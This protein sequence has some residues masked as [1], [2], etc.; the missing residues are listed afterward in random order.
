MTSSKAKD[1]LGDKFSIPT[2]PDIVLQVDALVRDPEAG[3]QEIGALIAQDAPLSTR[4][5][6]LANSAYYGLARRCASAEHA[7]S[8]LGVR[9]LRNIVTQ[10]AVFQAFDHLQGRFD[11]RPLWD[12]AQQTAKLC[13]HIVETIQHRILDPTELYTCGLIHDVGKIIML[14]ALGD[15]FA[16][17]A[18]EFEHDAD[19]ALAA[20]QERFQLTHPEVGAFVA[21]HWCLPDVIRATIEDHHGDTKKLEGDP[22]VAVVHA[23][24]RLVHAAPSLDDDGLI[25]I[26]SEPGI[27]SLAIEPDAARTIVE[28]VRSIA[29]SSVTSASWANDPWDD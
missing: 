13:S 10:V 15:E 27:A 6:K 14:E 18:K 3:I 29:H 25:A 7:C 24:D 23:A 16:Q 2:L 1:L 9:T 5:L 8:V 19:L 21:V 28:F 12:H 22:A 20:E 4:V 26:L 11:L 17:L